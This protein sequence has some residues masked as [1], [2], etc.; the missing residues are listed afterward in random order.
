ME[1]RRGITLEEWIK[2]GDMTPE[3]AAAYYGVDV[4]ALIRQERGETVSEFAQYRNRREYAG[5]SGRAL[6]HINNLVGLDADVR[7]VAD[8]LARLGPRCLQYTP[9][10]GEVT[11]A[12]IQQFI[13]WYRSPFRYVPSD[14]P[15]AFQ[16][17]TTGA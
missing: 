8:R 15:R 13:A 9:N 6:N 3:E 5:M 4:P 7:C 1:P 14:D 2:R 16:Q 17:Y 12:E 11:R 10:L